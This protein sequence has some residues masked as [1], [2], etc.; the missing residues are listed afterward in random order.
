M[1]VD[2]EVEKPSAVRIPDTVSGK[3]T[4]LPQ[5]S[6]QASHAQC[7][8]CCKRRHT[9]VDGLLYLMHATNKTTTPLCC[10]VRLCTGKLKWVDLTKGGF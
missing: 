4:Y 2:K 6:G 9:E 1:H 3:Q 8:L 7:K 5:A 10:W